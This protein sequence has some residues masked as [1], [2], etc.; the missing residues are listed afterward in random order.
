M[1]VTDLRCE[2]K[3]NPLGLDVR[4]PRFGWR[5]EDV[6]RGARQTAYQILVASTEHTLKVGRGDLWDSGVV[7]ADAIA[8]IAYAGAPLASRQ[9]A[10]WA[11]RVWDAAGKSSAWSA[12]AWFE[13]GLLEHADWQATWIGSALVGGRWTTIPCPY[14]RKEFR[15]T[16][17]VA[18]A[19]LYV[20]ALGLHEC[21]LNGMR[22]SDDVFA[23]GWTDYHTR[24]QYQVYDVTRL[25]VRGRNALGA[26]L[27]DGWYCGHVEWRGRQ[28]YGDRPRLLAQLELVFADGTR[29]TVVSDASWTCGFGALLESDM[30]MGESY[31]ARREFPGWD[32]PG[33][34]ATCWQPVCTFEDGGAAR[35]ASPGLPVVRAQE[36]LPVAPPQ[37]DTR[38][39]G[40][41]KWVFDL[42]QNMT[43]RIRLKIKGPR[44]TTVTIR[45]AEV[46]NP[47]GTIYTEN[48]R[49][50]RATDHYTLKGGG[51]EVYEPRFT[52]HGF[53][54]VELTGLP[55]DITPT[56]ASVTGIV[57]HSA[58]E[59]TGAFTC[60]E[61]LVNQLYKNIVWGHRGNFVDVPTDC[62]QRDERLG[63]T[64][65]A[66]V[67]IRTATFNADVAAFFTKWQR[68]LADAQ[69]FA[70]A[71]P[72]TAPD[73]NAVKAGDGGPAWADAV[74]ICP[75]T[76]YLCYGDTR[77]LAQHYPALQRFVEYIINRSHRLIRCNPKVDTWGGFGDWLSI[78]AE[79]PKD[80]IGTAFLAHSLA[81]MARIATALGKPADAQVY[82]NVHARVRA[83]FRRRFIATDG[84]LTAPTQ[85]AY[86]LALHFDLLPKQARR[87]AVR[88]LVADIKQRGMHLSTGFVGSPYLPHVL[89]ENGRADIAYRLLFQT[90]WPSWLYAVTQGATTIWERW[91][92]W[93]HDKGF[94]D[95]GMNSFN[96]YAYG[97]VG[98]WLFR[99]A[100]GIEADPARPAYKHILMRPCIARNGLTRVSASYD[101]L[102]GT[103]RSA[104]RVRDGALTWEVT[105]PPNCTATLHIPATKTA[106]VTEGGRPLAAGNG[107]TL[108]ARTAEACVITVPAGTYRLHS[109]ACLP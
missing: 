24:V 99:R 93:T 1:R 39:W 58:L 84:T 11:V 65:D 14:L 48:L 75:W 40:K 27:G 30:L 64:G 70:G 96:H 60:N 108:V 23:P 87:N 103:I 4:A 3:C 34:D 61:P 20:T 109:S 90:S 82:R 7:R 43:G 25:I 38:Q 45:H 62:P 72:P 10:W 73:T 102:P 21:S 16:K 86:V 66:Q 69:G 106:R 94:Q 47:D 54:Y 63:W 80:L 5:L 31:D 9:R 50:A 88:A 36:L 97:A 8:Q 92:G 85:T 17:R 105:I 46:L 77:L 78:K 89:S 49:T 59:F 13:M 22:V 35:V 53:R 76:L 67:F 101:A 51:T 52:F 79:T 18:T 104:W 44:G 68:D 55:D 33:F 74:V 83:A 100:A 98:D 12:P 29:Q 71:I 91:D 57:L 2:Y 95:V 19:R 15:V 41:T 6:R 56:R 37:K 107:V 32:T 28:L 81:L 42:G 26:M